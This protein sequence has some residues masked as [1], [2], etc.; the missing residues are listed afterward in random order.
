MKKYF[1]IAILFVSNSIVSQTIET[2]WFEPI[3]Y[4]ISSKAEIVKVTKTHLFYFINNKSSATFYKIDFN[5]EEKFSK[6][7]SFPNINSHSIFIQDIV[8]FNN[9][10]LLI[11]KV[12]TSDRISLMAQKINAAG[13]IEKDF[14]ML[15]TV[16]SS[17]K[18]EIELDFAVSPDKRNSATVTS[19]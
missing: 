19:N 7:F 15:S 10:F 5:G 18:S 6:T 2:K 16:K 11:V 13:E 4:S 12:S 17:E 8:E 14:L 3:S 9:Q 1:F